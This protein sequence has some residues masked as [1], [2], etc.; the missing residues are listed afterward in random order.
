MSKWHKFKITARIKNVHKNAKSVKIN[1]C[2]K[3]CCIVSGEGMSYCQ[4][5]QLF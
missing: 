1:V 2:L 4:P 5:Q 3:D